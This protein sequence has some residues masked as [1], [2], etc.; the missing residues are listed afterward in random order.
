MTAHDDVKKA[1]EELVATLN[2]I[3]DKQ[4]APDGHP[5]VKETYELLLSVGHTGESA[6]EVML[7]AISSEIAEE[8]TVEHGF[9]WERY[10]VLLEEVRDTVKKTF[11]EKSKPESK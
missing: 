9:N 10:L 6:R 1:R 8:S 3:L 11:L 4:L 2:M 5:A 7:M